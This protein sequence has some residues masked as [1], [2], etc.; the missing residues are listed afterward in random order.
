[1]LHPH[2]E[3]TMLLHPDSLMIF[4]LHLGQTRMEALLIA[5]ST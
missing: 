2:F 1:M 3:Q 4:T 5:S